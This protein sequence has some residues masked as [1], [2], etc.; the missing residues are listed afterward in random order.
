M[1]KTLAQLRTFTRALLSEPSAKYWSDSELNTYIN[2]GIGLFCDLTDC[3]DDISTNS[4]IQYQSDY[5]CPTDYTKIQRIEYIRGN[6]VYVVND[7]T[8]HEQYTG[9]TRNSMS[10]PNRANIIGNTIRFDIRP[11][12]AAGA[13]TL[14][15]DHTSSATTITVADSSDFP[16]EGRILIDSEVIEYFNNDGDN[17]ELEVCTRGMEGTTAASHSDGATVTLRDIWVYH[18]KRAATLS[19]DT[20][21]TELPVQFENAAAHY[22]AYIG[23]MKSKD[24]DLATSQKN[25]FEEYVTRGLDWAKQKIKRSYRPR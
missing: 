25:V 3:L 24:Y 4:G 5:T 2:D 9:V 19:S 21:T 10:Q 8:L 12:S 17:E 15:G 14:D 11:N 22:A 23:R 7:S 20:D 13:S 16:R 1:A 6:S 18:Y